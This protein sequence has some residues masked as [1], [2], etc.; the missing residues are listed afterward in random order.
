MTKT[1]EKK[2]QRYLVIIRKPAEVQVMSSGIQQMG[3]TTISNWPPLVP[4]NPEI[5]WIQAEDA[6]DAVEQ[7]NLAPNANALV[8][9][10]EDVLMFRR[11]KIATLEIVEGKELR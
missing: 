7:C 3:S 4:A 10:G 5:K 11:P 9:H 8:V 6:K 1:V 2:R